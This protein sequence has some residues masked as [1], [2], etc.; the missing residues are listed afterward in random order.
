MSPAVQS[1]ILALVPTERQADVIDLPARKRDL[2]RRRNA[3]LT[4]ARSPETAAEL[5][6]TADL[7][8]AEI[9]A[10]PAALRLICRRL[11]LGGYVHGHMD[12]ADDDRAAIEQ[13]DT[14]TQ[15]TV[16]QLAQFVAARQQEDGA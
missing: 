10:N 16:T 2:G 15:A 14:L 7:A 1:P 8:A 3:A 11:I 13:A 5:R 12:K 9:A 4:A 6:E